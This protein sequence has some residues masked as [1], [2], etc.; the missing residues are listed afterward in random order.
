M[1]H[2]INTLDKSDKTWFAWTITTISV[3]VIA[4]LL[5]L[6][7]GSCSAEKRAE[8]HL[9]RAY[10]LSPVTVAKRCSSYFIPTTETS[11]DTQYLLSE[12]IEIHDSVFVDCDSVIN[13]FELQHKKVVRVK[14]PC[15]PCPPCNP[16]VITKTVTVTANNTAI[17]DAADKKI[18]DYR[19][20][21]LFWFKYSIVVSAF[22]LI[23]AALKYF[24]A[25]IRGIVSIL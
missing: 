8:K 9:N 20:K 17:L 12:P 23:F 16:I 6:A 7:L 10:V 11:L 4:L 3:A 22:V 25:Q 18:N 2:H 15:P 21:Y 19:D 1:K 24:N 13:A 14:V 5:S